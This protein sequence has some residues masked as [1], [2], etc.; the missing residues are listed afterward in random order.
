[1]QFLPLSVVLSPSGRFSNSF[2]VAV[3]VAARCVLKISL[4]SPYAVCYHQTRAETW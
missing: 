4:R 2:F 3:V 1:M